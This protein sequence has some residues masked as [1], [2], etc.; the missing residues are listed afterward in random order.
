MDG[1]YQSLLAPSPEFLATVKVF[2]LIPSLKKDVAR[3]IDSALSWDQLTASDI[4]FSIVR[5]I[6]LKY[7]KLKNMAVVYACLVV[8][9]YFLAESEAELAYAGVMHS[10]AT[11]CEILAMK[12]LSRFASNHIQLVAV[13]TTRW[14]P[15]AGAPFEIAEQVRQA[16]GGDE[17]D[18]DSAQ[19]ALEMAISTQAKAFLASPVSQKVVNDIYSG[20]IVFSMSGSRSILADNYKPRAIE[21][22]DCRTAPFIDHYRLRVPRYG[23][24][25][26]FLNFALLLLTFILCLSNQDKAAVTVW[27]MAFVLFAVAF[28]LEEY[29]A[30]TEHGWIIYIANLWNVFDFSFIAVFILYLV[31]RIQGLHN[32]D[33]DASSMAFDILSCGAC[34]L[35][36]RLAFFA[37]SN[38]VVILSLRAMVS[39]FVFFIGIAAVCFSGLLFALWTLGKDADPAPSLKSIAWLMTQIWFGNTSLSF[40]QAERFHPV[41]GPILMITFAALANTLLLTILISLLSNTVARI[42]ANATQEYL[43]QFAIAT[44]EGVKSDALFSYQP[45]FNILAFVILK[46]AT[47]FLSPRALHSTN[48]FL[49]KLTSLPTLILIGVYERYFAAGQRFRESGRDAAQSLFN[50]LPRHI[51]NMPL[52][53]ALVGS[54]SNGVYEAIFDVDFT[55]EM[56][57]FD[58]SDDDFP[59]LQSFQSSTRNGGLQTTPTPKRKKLRPS[60]LGP[61]SPR[62]SP[63]ARSLNPPVVEPSHSAELPASSSRSPLA[64]L[65]GSRMPSSDSVTRVE[66]TA[67]RIEVLM[68]DLHELPVQKLKEE[69]KDLQ[70][71]QA[72]IESLLLVLTR[73]M[74]NETH[75]QETFP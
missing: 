4:N 1:E 12:L 60:S 8:R 34:I 38:N 42:D 20:R 28:T 25:L 68:K 9:S 13:L 62:G 10:R 69:M 3:T 59:T 5:P 40:G 53:E 14:N 21:L 16:V 52:V 18:I 35:F 33:L 70:D 7:A 67:N 2:P 19:S 30:A 43:F 24:I 49:I 63:R 44:M 23:A 27:E 47:W 72:R 64:V 15:L 50:S 46:P 66:A 58:D 56:E 74:R 73:G 26:E 45:P 41:F 11:L 17:D 37:I 61:P 6:V 55:S 29:T 65:F 48:V 22:Y 57:L 54:S 39:Q 36:P 75:R 51:K 31:L 71:R 32:N